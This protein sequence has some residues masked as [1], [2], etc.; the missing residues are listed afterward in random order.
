MWTPRLNGL[1]AEDAGG[2]ALVAYRHGSNI[3][4][5]QLFVMPGGRS[6]SRQLL[7]PRI[8]LVGADAL[9][10]ADCRR[11]V[12]GGE[13]FQDDLKLLGRRPSTAFSLLMHKGDLLAKSMSP[14]SPMEGNEARRGCLRFRR[15]GMGTLVPHSKRHL[16]KTTNCAICY[17]TV[18]W[19]C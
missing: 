11:L 12:F 9:A 2:P 1:A 19:N 16:F 18:E 6:S 4:L 5:K 10:A 17:E 8:D 3:R 14:W 7:E 15:A 13:G